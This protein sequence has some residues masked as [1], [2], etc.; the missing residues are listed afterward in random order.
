MKYTKLKKAFLLGAALCAMQPIVEA[1]LADASREPADEVS[2][3]DQAKAALNDFDIKFGGR[4]KQDFFLWEK[5]FLFG[6]DK[7]EV[8]WYLRSKIEAGVK[9]Q[10]GKKVY[11]KPATEAAIKFSAYGYWQGNDAYDSHTKETISLAALDGATTGDR[12]WHRDIMP[13]VYLEE[14]WYKLNFGAFVPALEDHPISLTVGY[15]PYIIGR[16]LS[17]GVHNDLANTYAGWEG[18]SRYTRFP[19]MPPGILVRGQVSENFTWD[20]YYNKWRANNYALERL[21]APVYQNRLNWPSVY[22]SKDK[23]R[24]TIALRA[25]L[26]VRPSESGKLDFQPY[27]IYTRAP[28]LPVEFEADS[29]ARLGTV[30]CM[31]E[32]DNNGWNINVEMAGQF[33]TQEMFAF[34][35]NTVVLEKDGATGNVQEK[36]T[37]LRLG[38]QATGSKAAVTTELLGI[39]NLARNRTLERNG[40]QLQTATG[41]S[42]VQNGQ[43]VFNSNLWGNPRIRPT[44]KLNYSGLMGLADVAY[45]FKKTP[46]KAAA[47]VGYIGGD[48]YP[49]NTEEGSNREISKSYKGFI[50]QRGFYSGKNVH[51]I[52]ILEQLVVPRPTNIVNR[53]LY[54]ENNYRDYS[55]LQFVGTNVV[56][57]PL[58][59]KEK[60]SIE[61]NIL[62][63]WEVSDLKKW[64]MNAQHPD[65]VIRAQLARAGITGWMSDKNA[66]KFLGTELNTMVTYNIFK[67]CSFCWKGWIFKPGQLYYDL[68][69][70]P[71]AFGRRKNPDGSNV[72]LTQGTDASW[73]FYTGIDYKF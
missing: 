27:L 7:D 73:G 58:A 60:L 3:A 33:G 50:A 65:D 52:M 24:D 20:I 54:A 5:P 66:S 25:D 44:Y 32:W 64:D 35:R 69:G 45:S 63:F 12:H 71:N 43:A 67:N 62:G 39:A 51:S 46:L 16:G 9:V 56:W 34:D 61:P 42:Y 14:G 31:S 30:G 38:N 36:F 48:K 22:R 4:V 13:R 37:H 55:N 10:Q 21:Y 15:F 40:Q 29:K 6:A 72:I 53:L 23:D 2:M 28:E 49:Y 57:Y 18:L 1:R 41:A 59:Q 8:A 68:K 26:R 11:G 17:L 47:S 19:S 70:Q